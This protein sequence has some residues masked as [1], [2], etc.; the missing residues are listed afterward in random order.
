MAEENVPAPIRTDDQLNSDLLCGA[1]GITP[2]DPTHPFVAPLSGDLVIDFVNNLEHP[3]DLQFVSKMYVNNP[4]TQFF[5]CY[6]GLSQ[7]P[8]STMQ[9]SF[10]KSLY[11]NLKFVFKGEVDEV[12]GM[13]IP[14][15]LITDTIR[16]SEY[17]KKY[18]EMA[19]CKPRQPTTVTHEEGG[20]KKKAPPAVMKVRKGKK[21]D[22]H[23][24]EDD[25][26][27]HAPEPQVEDDEYNLQRGIQMSLESLQAHGQAPVSGVAI[28][29]PTSVST[30]KLP[31]VEGK[32]KGI[33]TDK[34]AAQSLLDLQQPKKKSTT[35]HYIFQRRTPITQDAST[36][37][38]TQP[39]DDTSM[40]LVHDTPSPADAETSADTKKSN[41]EADTEILNVGEE[42]VKDV[43]NMVALKERTIKLDE[44][45]AGS[46]PVYPAVHENLKLT[47]E[48]QV[49]IENPLSSSGTLSSMKNL[50]DAFTFGD[51]FI[52]DKSTEE[53]SGKANVETK[54]ESMPTVPIHQAFSLV[55][56]LS[57]PIIDLTPPKPVSTPIQE[58]ICTTTTTTT[59]LPPPPP[60]LPHST[61]DSDLS[62]RVTALEKR[63][64]D[65]EQKHQIQD[66]TMKAIASRVYKL[67][68]HDLYSKIDKQVNEVVKE[69]VRNALQASLYECFRDLSGFQMKEILHDQMFKSGSY[70][71]HLNHTTLYEALEVSMQ[72]DNNDELHEALATSRKRCQ[73]SSSS[74][75]KKPT[76]PLPVN[77]DPI[78]D[79][80][81]L[82]ESEDTG[83]SHLPKI[84]TRL[85]WLKPLPKEEAPETLE[86]EWANQV[87]HNISKPLPLGGPPGQVTIQTQYFF[88]SDLEY[89]V[90][91]NKE[92][93]HALSIS[94][95]KSAYYLDFGLEELVPSLWTESKSAYDI[96]SAYG[97]SHW[98]FKRKEFY[99]TRHSAP[100]DRRAVRSNMRI[101]SVVSLKTFSK[102]SYT[103][104]KEIVLRRADYK[105]YKI[106]EAGFKVYIR[107]ILKTCTYFIFNARS[108]TYLEQTKL[109]YPPP[110]TCGLGTSSS[111]NGWKTYNSVLRDIKRISTLHNRGDILKKFGYS[112]V[113][114]SNT[115]MDKENPWGKYGT[116]KDVD[117]HLY[118]SMIRSLMC[119]TASRPDIMFAV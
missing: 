15:D 70:K 26:V 97:I 115:P 113:R 8:M 17:Y 41:S 81:H 4:D 69:A 31:D 3:E 103:Y 105:K 99:I 10:G 111:D 87:V 7:E 89:L 42:Q 55:P 21:S 95:L 13:L 39:Q 119:L 40:N 90:S 74:S 67:E 23:V 76:S 80:M 61:T 18:L 78:P 50:E 60:L 66:K 118:R 58:P 104:L 88:N 45:R 73:A 52:N 79:D 71:S 35:D 110:L 109:P 91:G 47:T 72:R 93:R 20:K 65:F 5:K 84:K 19:A 53:E 36:G 82:S 101:L 9:N 114:S 43:S 62:N 44:G 11:S 102:Y 59:T 86:P 100:S 28:H 54:V 77:D 112:E 117:L 106:S 96:S 2:K 6:G 98:W 83:A 1:L 49:N 85:D 51:Q 25:E 12:F 92:R 56:P 29:E 37:P 116:E 48:E 22:D 46:N 34:Q 14:K 108:T 107:M 38:S 32:G 57:T 63:S 64:A 68:H 94:K 33:V 24:D 30:Q 16:N 27:Q 75:K